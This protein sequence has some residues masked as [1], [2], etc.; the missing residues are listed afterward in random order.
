MQ[1]KQCL[2]YHYGNKVWTLVSLH[3]QIK[4][5]Q[6]RDFEGTD[7]HLRDMPLPGP[8]PCKCRFNYFGN[9]YYMRQYDIA[10][11]DGWVVAFGTVRRGLGD[12]PPRSSVAVHISLLACMLCRQC[13]E[14]MHRDRLSR[15][16]DMTVC[17][18]R[19]TFSQFEPT[20]N[21]ITVHKTTHS[22]WP[23]HN[24]W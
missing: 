7:K 14:S 21:I 10:T 4:Y 1:Y 2:C 20:Y 13:R 24:C 9:F 12:A 16:S 8:P 6:F 3:Q 5:K 19:A 17:F 15:D 22:K 11:R 23:T 18:V